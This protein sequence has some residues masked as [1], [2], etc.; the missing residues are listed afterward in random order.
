MKELNLAE[1]SQLPKGREESLKSLLGKGASP[2][3]FFYLVIP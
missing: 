3:R 1:F 2:A